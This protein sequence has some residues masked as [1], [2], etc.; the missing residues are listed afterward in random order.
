MSEIC[1]QVHEWVSGVDSFGLPFPEERVPKN[2]SYVLFEEGEWGHDT[3]R[4]VRIGTHTGANQLRGRLKQHFL[5]RNKDRSIFR[6]NI[7]RALLQRDGDPFL[8]QWEIDL[9]TRASRERYGADVDREKLASLEQ[10]VSEV[11]QTRFRFAVF[12]IPDRQQRLHLESRLVSTVSLCTDCGPSEQWLGRRSPKE[13]VQ[14][15][16]LWQVNELYKEPLTPQDLQQLRK[17]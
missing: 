14:E 6:K 15:S 17:N 7:G 11:I 2:G 16:G 10:R 3:S 9:T 5:N 13:K 1:R 8:Q 4:I 12:K